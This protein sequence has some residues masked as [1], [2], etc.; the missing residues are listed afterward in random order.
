MELDAEVAVS[1][2]ESLSLKLGLRIPLPT[3]RFLALIV[4]FCWDYSDFI[5][6][7]NYMDLLRFY[8]L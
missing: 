7:L 8:N 5:K 6:I 3:I 1:I 2:P 4:F